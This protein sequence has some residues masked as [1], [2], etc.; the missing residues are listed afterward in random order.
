MIAPSFHPATVRAT[1]RPR[2]RASFGLT[3]RSI[4]LLTAGFAFLIPGFWDARLSYAMLA[5][6]ALVLLAAVLDGMR[7]PRATRLAAARAW[8]NAP[9]LDSQTE[10]ELTV[11]NHGSVIIECRLIDDLPSALGD[12]SARQ[13]SIRITAFPRV[14]AAVRYRVEP[15]ERGDCTTGQLY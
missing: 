9:S 1:C 4:A 5:W 14:P 13:E 10:I 8:S 2:T 11:E 3:T 15:Q 7:L 6:D 12:P